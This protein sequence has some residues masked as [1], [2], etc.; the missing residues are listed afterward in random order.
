VVLVLLVALVAFA[1]TTARLFVWPSLPPLP[2]RADAIIEIGGPGDRDAAARALAEE[3]RAPLLI[4]ST[5]ARDAKSDTCLPP[6]AGVQIGCFVAVPRTTRGEARWIGAQGVLH[7]WRS[8]IVVTSRDHAWRARLRIGRCF[9]G[10]VY[11]RTTPL[12]HWYTWLRQI[13]YQWVATVKA[14]LFQRAC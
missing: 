11:V 6:V 3:H 2:A 5:Q 13:P 12:P 10:E 8:V 4:Q 7:N 14:E 1:A 9:P